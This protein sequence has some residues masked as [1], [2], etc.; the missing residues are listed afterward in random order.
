MVHKRQRRLLQCRRLDLPDDAT[1]SRISTYGDHYSMAQQMFHRTPARSFCLN[2]DAD[3]RLLK[4]VT[5]QRLTTT[6]L[7]R[8]RC[9]TSW[10]GHQTPPRQASS[11]TSTT[12]LMTTRMGSKRFAEE[13]QPTH[14]HYHQKRTGTLRI[15]CRPRLLSILLLLLTHRCMLTGIRR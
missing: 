5:M 12:L 2:L 1:D 15:L 9:S 4:H 11:S 8:S 7:S 13:E 6:S 14:R 3:K 10:T